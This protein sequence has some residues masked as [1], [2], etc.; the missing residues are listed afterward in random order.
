MTQGYIGVSGRFNK[1]MWEHFKLEGNRHLKFAINKHGWDNL[2][3]TQILIADEAYC[4]DIERKL[5]PAEGIGWNCIAGGGKPPVNRWNLGTKGVMKAWN[6]G[7]VMLPETRVKISAAVTEAMKDPKRREINRKALLGKTGLMVGKKHRPESI[8]KMRLSHAGKVSKKKGRA[9]TGE[10][11]ANLSAL[12]RK[13][14][15]ACPH[16]QTVGYGVG[17]KNRWHF[18]NCNLKEI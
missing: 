5:R 13:N 9:L 18:D 8:E 4:L 3:K 6:K 7:K 2:V 11:K 14:P 17:A 10:Q 1:R 12:I 15:W 16:C